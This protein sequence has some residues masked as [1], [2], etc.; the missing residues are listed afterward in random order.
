MAKIRYDSGHPAGSTPEQRIVNRLK[1]SGG[2][3]ADTVLKKG[4]GPT[5]VFHNVHSRGQGSGVG[6]GPTVG[7]KS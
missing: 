1:N 6:R 5:R 3:N 4:D 7:N 2:E